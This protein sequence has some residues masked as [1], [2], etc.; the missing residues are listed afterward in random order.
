MPNKTLLII[1]TVLALVLGGIFY[2][3]YPTPNEYEAAKE[4]KME[5]G[6]IPDQTKKPGDDDVYCTADAFLCPDG[7]YIGRSGPNCEFKCPGQ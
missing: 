1:F 5:D 6:T 3:V 4:E 7:S 2:L